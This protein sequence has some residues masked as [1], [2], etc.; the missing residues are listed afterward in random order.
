ML[1]QTYFLANFGTYESVIL[2]FV[3]FWLYISREI[4]AIKVDTM[5]TDHDWLINCHM[6]L[7]VLQNSAHFF[8]KVF[9]NF[10]ES[11]KMKWYTNAVSAVLIGTALVSKYDH[12]CWF[13][14]LFNESF[15]ILMHVPALLF[16]H[17]RWITRAHVLLLSWWDRNCLL[18]FNTRFQSPLFGFF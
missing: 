10:F 3:V 13:H 12:T 15:Y 1:V 6:R 17:L 9:P 16:L 18:Y 7:V 2:L 8:Q 5:V 11:F 4:C 14:S